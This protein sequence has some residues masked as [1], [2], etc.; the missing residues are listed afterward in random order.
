MNAHDLEYFKKK[1][2]AE[3]A[4]LEGELSRIG[5]RDPSTPG[6]WEP[7]SGGMEVDTADE[8]ELA[9]KMEEMEENAGIGASLEKELAE[10]NAALD[11]MKK[12]TYGIDESTGKPIDRARLEAN[13]S[14]RTAVKK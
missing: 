11:R 14:A 8:N 13:P 10:V 4:R 2:T 3:K 1:L 5:K 6:G 7:T 9:D 12:G